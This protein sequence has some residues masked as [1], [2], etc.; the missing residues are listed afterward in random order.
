MNAKSVTIGKKEM[1]SYRH[2]SATT[3]AHNPFWKI[4]KCFAQIQLFSEDRLCV[5]G[6]APIYIS[7]P[8]QV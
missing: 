7:Y 8:V 4:W 2:V 3:V 1:G 6:T 5:W